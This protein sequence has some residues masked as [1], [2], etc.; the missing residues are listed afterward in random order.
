M[1]VVVTTHVK[2]EIHLCDLQKNY[3]N[4]LKILIKGVTDGGTKH[5][6]VT[7]N[8]SNGVKIN[9]AWKSLWDHTFS[10]KE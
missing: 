5:N 3:S 8:F 2:E 1:V 6:F 7:L 9:S 4:I 10:C